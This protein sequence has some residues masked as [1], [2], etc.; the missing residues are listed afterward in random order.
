LLNIDSKIWSGT[1]TSTTAWRFWNWDPSN[2]RDYTALRVGTLSH[3]PSKHEQFT[4]EIRWAGDLSSRLSA[5]FGLYGFVQ[6]LETDPVHTEEVGA[7]DFRFVWNPS[8]GP[9]GSP[10]IAVGPGGSVVDNYFA[11]PRSEITSQLDTFTTAV[12]SQLD[13]AIPER[14]HLLPGLRLNYDKKEVDFQQRAVNVASVT[15]VD[16]EALCLHRPIARRAACGAVA[17]ELNP[18]RNVDSQNGFMPAAPLPLCAQRFNPRVRAALRRMQDDQHAR[19]Q[20]LRAPTVCGL[21]L[22]LRVKPGEP[23]REGDADGVVQIAFEGCRIFIGAG[24]QPEVE[25]GSHPRAL[26]AASAGAQHEADGQRRSDWSGA[27]HGC[28]RR[29]SG[30]HS[31]APS[32]STATATSAPWRT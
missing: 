27:A 6:K 26:Q 4:Q 21:P 7:D 3:A 31:S 9:N 5:V 16:A 29:R 12:F 18:R 32:E 1:L 22:A 15:G 13:W 28:A 11:G 30:T 10:N 23:C 2:D 25:F 20:P 8:P 14:L 24:A 19:V 17:L